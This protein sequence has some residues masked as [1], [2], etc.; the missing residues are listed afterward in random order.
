LLAAFAQLDV[1]ERRLRATR[2]NIT[3]DLEQVIGER[4]RLQRHLDSS[5]EKSA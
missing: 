3:Y 1:R 5:E 2:A 4:M